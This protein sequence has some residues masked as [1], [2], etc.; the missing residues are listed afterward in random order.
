MESEPG[1]KLCCSQKYTVGG[2]CAPNFIPGVSPATVTQNFSVPKIPLPVIFPNASFVNDFPL[3]LN[4]LPFNLF[5]IQ[6]LN[7]LS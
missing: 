6:C 3:K 2:W 5:G 4:L 7:F 1:L